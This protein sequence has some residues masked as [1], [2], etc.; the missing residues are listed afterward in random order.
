MRQLADIFAEVVDRNARVAE[1]GRIV[2]PK[3]ELVKD[4]P[5]GVPAY[6]EFEIAAGADY[7]TLEV[8]GASIHQPLREGVSVPG[9]TGPTSTPTATPVP[10][11]SN[12]PRDM[13]F[14]GEKDNDAEWRDLPLEFDRSRPSQEQNRNGF[15]LEQQQ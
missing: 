7:F 15:D 2:D 13:K 6:L 1:K 9:S 4:Y 3:G 14:D 11:K 5:A 10:E 12:E 8:N